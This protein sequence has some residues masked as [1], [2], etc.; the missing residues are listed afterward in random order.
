MCVLYSQCLHKWIFV[1]CITHLQQTFDTDCIEDV[2]RSLFRAQ[3]LTCTPPA[4]ADHRRPAVAV[5]SCRDLAPEDFRTEA[6]HLEQF[7]CNFKELEASIRFPS[8]LY[9]SQELLVLSREMGKELSRVFRDAVAFGQ[10]SDASGSL[11]QHAADVRSILGVPQEPLVDRLSAYMRMI[12]HDQFI[13][14]V[15][16]PSG[17]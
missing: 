14:G 1:V 9:A 16:V 7:K 5:L 10:Q 15:Q 6:S 13:H 17:I 4:P 12:F 2:T 8:P 3:T 11:Q